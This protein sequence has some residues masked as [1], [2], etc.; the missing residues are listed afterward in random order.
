MNR[1]N[2]TLY[3]KIEK[4]CR[5]TCLLLYCTFKLN[6]A[7]LPCHP[8]LTTSVWIFSSSVGWLVMSSLRSLLRISSSTVKP[9]MTG[10]LSSGRCSLLSL[11][12]ATEI[13]VLKPCYQ[14][15]QNE[16]RC[17]INYYVYLSMNLFILACLSKKLVNLSLVN[18]FVFYKHPIY[19]NIS[20]KS[21]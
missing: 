11:A 7:Y 14:S 10:G 3:N 6:W 2:I 21:T 20:V 1:E 15:C 8:P 5:H 16:M 17:D 13:K 19:I 18:I 9:D 4:I 12:G